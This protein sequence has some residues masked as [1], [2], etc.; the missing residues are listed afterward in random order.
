MPSCSS[1]SGSIPRV[2][3]WRSCA[4]FVGVGVTGLLGSCGQGVEPSLEPAETDAVTEVPDRFLVPDPSPVAVDRSRPDAWGLQDSFEG[5]GVTR[6]TDRFGDGAVRRVAYYLPGPAV[7]ESLHGPEWHYFPNGTLKNMQYWR[8]GSQ[9][10][11]FRCWFP[12]GLLRWDGTSV[13][14][15]RDGTYRQYHKGGDLQYVYE[16]SAGVPQGTWS[17]YLAGGVLSQEEQFEAG[18]LHG[19]RRTWVRAEGED[20]RDPDAGGVSFPVV[21]ETYEAGVLHGPTTRYHLASDVVQAKGVYDQGRRNGLWETF[22]P[23]GQLATSCT[24]EGGFKEGVET[25]FGPEGHKV[26]SVEHRRGI[27]HGLSESW[28]PDGVLQSRGPLADGR[29]NG[30]WIYQRPDGTPNLVWSGTYKDDEKVSDSPMP[31]NSASE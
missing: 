4:L 30:T 1:I 10:G 9:Q 22:H 18:Q 23:N 8:R 27:I 15:Q 17:E 12:S 28:Y 21:D 11:V 26:S 2:L 31:A 14:G 7:H 13:G 16:Y 20:P 25:T 3:R 19:R 5:Q 24:H 29:R 6:V